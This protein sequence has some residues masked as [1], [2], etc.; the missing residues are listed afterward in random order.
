MLGNLSFGLRVHAC[1]T[2]SDMLGVLSRR[3]CLSHELSCV[4]CSVYAS[5]PIALSGQPNSKRTTSL[6]HI[7]GFLKQQHNHILQTIEFH[8]EIER[9]LTCQWSN[10]CPLL[11][12]A[13][14]LSEIPKSTTSRQPSATARK[15]HCIG[16][17][18]RSTF[19]GVDGVRR[20]CLRLSPVL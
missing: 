3:P 6:L 8:F 18:L 5:M 17:L 10:R 13:A 19:G 15:Q 12:T 7:L 16:L 14:R 20:A 1:R 9:C 4:G 11:S 2:S